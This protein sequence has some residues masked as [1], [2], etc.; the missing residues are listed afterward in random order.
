MPLA[1]G[2][3]IHLDQPYEEALEK[4]T[5]A[6]KSQGFGILTRV[7]VK[8]TLKEKLGEE[9]RNYIILGACNPALSHR[10]LSTDPVVGLILPCN[11]TVE[12]DPLGGSLVRIGNP[13]AIM[14]LGTW[15]ENEILRDVAREARSRLELAAEAL[16]D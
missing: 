15:Q 10:A 14:S 5:A 11:V 4:V 3:E 13:E 8:A 6:L 7:D 1:I 16:L 12:D 2:F 9:F